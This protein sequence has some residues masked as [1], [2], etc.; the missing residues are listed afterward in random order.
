MSEDVEL[1]DLRD[2]DDGQMRCF[3]HIGEHGIVV[4]RAGGEL[5][6]LDDNCSHAATPLSTGRLRGTTLTCPL[7][8]AQFDVR[9]G[10]HLSPPA[11]CGVAT[12]RLDVGDEAAV[13]VTLP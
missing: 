8:G 3:E 13:R 10:S 1:G 7:H 5:F 2:L 11:F 9:D 12:H 6:A 4:C